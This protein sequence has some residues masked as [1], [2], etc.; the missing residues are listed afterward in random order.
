MSETKVRRWWASIGVGAA[1]CVGCCLAPLLAAI[2]VAGGGVALLSV[3]WLEPLGFALM[4]VGI[5]GLVWSRVR[6][7]R[8]GCRA[9]GD[10]S[11]GDCGSGSCG[12]G[13]AVSPCGSTELPLLPHPPGS[14]GDGPASGV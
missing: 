6:A 1:I 5:A 10:D 14:R 7:A 8:R 4:G 12:C 3:S 2:G 13:T 9:S 11:N